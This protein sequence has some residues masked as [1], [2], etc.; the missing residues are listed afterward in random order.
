MKLNRKS[1]KQI[2][3]ER[4]NLIKRTKVSVIDYPATLDLKF[5]TASIKIFKKIKR[6]DKRRRLYERTF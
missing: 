3:A 4:I 2:L 1:K 5:Y 6:K